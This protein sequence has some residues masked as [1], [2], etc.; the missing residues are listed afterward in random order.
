LHGKKDWSSDRIAKVAEVLTLDYMS[1]EESDTDENG[2]NVYK[3]KRLPWQSNALK[4]R[5][6]SLDKQHLKSLPALVKR[7]L[8]PRN[9]GAAVSLRPKPNDCPDWACNEDN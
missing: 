9:V 4:K 6:E 8:V 1:S 2:K 7:R 5:K 3:V